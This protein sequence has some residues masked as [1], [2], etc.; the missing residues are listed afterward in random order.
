ME[1]DHCLGKQ[2]IQKLGKN[3]RKMSVI[4][5]TKSKLT[6]LGRNCMNCPKLLGSTVNFDKGT[7]YSHKSNNRYWITA[8]TKMKLNRAAFQYLLIFRKS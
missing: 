3:L 8:K 1:T 5:S 2:I 6:V 4:S 7:Q